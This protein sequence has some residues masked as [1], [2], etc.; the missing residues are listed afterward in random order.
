M[1]CHSHF[2]S[3]F[4]Q[5]N[6]ILTKFIWNNKKARLQLKLLYLLCGRGYL[7]LPNLR[8]YDW[9]AQL[10]SATLYL[11]SDIPPAWVNIQQTTTSH[12][13]L[14]LYLCLADLKTLRKK[15]K[16][17]FLKNAINIYYHVHQHGWWVRMF[18]CKQSCAFWV[19]TQKT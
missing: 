6:N 7:R 4:D 11:H 18:P 2:P 13:P 1:L 5:I 12:L 16:N 9:S 8:W 15:T 3:V 19:Y 10:H 17:P 14:K